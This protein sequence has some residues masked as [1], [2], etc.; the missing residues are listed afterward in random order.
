VKYAQAFEIGTPDA[1]KITQVNLVKLGATTHSFDADQRLIKL[2]FTRG[3]ER[4]SIQTPSNGTFAPPGHYM[5]FILND[6][7]VPSMARIIK[8]EP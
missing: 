8:L 1:D 6:S 3:S 4:L 5:L 7:G 2:A